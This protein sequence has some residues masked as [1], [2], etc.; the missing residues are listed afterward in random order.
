[1]LEKAPKDK[2]IRSPRKVSDEEVSTPAEIKS[3]ALREREYS[4]P[5]HGITIKATSILDAE[6]KLLE[7]I[8][9]KAHE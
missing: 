7:I 4:F 5:A 8:S 6:K 9:K 3:P 1:M 2:M